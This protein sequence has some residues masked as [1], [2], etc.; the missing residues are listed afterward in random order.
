MVGVGKVNILHK[1]YIDEY[2]K[3]TDY[4][5][6]S[7]LVISRALLQPN[8]YFAMFFCSTVRTEAISLET[9]TDALY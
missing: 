3:W 6:V 2:V 5:D 8:N 1:F 9:I 7:N 4:Q